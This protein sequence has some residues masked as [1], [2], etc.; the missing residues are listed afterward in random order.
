MKHPTELTYEGGL[1]QLVTD[2]GNLR[3]DILFCFLE[4]LANKLEKDASADNKKDRRYLARRLNDAADKIKEAAWS[5]GGAW[6]ISEK[7]M[8]E[9]N[10]FQNDV[11]SYLMTKSIIFN[12]KKGTFYVLVSNIEFLSSQIAQQ[13]SFN[14]TIS[15]D[16]PSSDYLPTIKKESSRIISTSIPYGHSYEEATIFGYTFSDLISLTRN[17]E[18][19]RNFVLDQRKKRDER[20]I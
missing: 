19:F 12:D 17:I 16:P 13:C 18:N 5:I 2:L 3:Y 20:K 8:K 4:N 14:F 9:E 6:S 1:D 11:L 15:D 10:T 7:F